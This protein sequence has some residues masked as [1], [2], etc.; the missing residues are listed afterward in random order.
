MKKHAAMA[1]TPLYTKPAPRQN[2]ST[3]KDRGSFEIETRVDD[4]PGT[5]FSNVCGTGW[6]NY[7]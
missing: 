3:L 6:A 2:D 7:V 4:L 1:M 5:D